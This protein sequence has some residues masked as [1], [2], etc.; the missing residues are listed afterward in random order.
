MKKCVCLLLAAVL[1]LTAGCALAA[2]PEVGPATSETPMPVPDP[3][4][5]TVTDIVDRAEEENL[6]TDTALE[7]FWS[8]GEYDYYFPTVRSRY[9]SVYYSDGTEQTVRAALE[10]GRIAIADLNT[11]GVDYHK[12]AILRV[13]DI[14]DRTETE[15]LLTADA[16]EGF[17]RDEEYTY[18]FASIKSHYIIVHYSDGTQ[19]PIR[20]AMAR[21]DVTIGDL[22]R[23]GIG[24]YKEAIVTAVGMECKM[25]VL[26]AEKLFWS[27]EDYDYYFPN[28]DTEV[29]V[30]LSDGHSWPLH[31]ALMEGLVTVGDLEKYDIEYIRV[32]KE[33]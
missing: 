22:D 24:Y 19:L 18:A 16:L 29:T 1:L 28:Y 33:K 20:E 21:G 7:L 6:P 12:E 17:W 15:A 9:V 2:E 14:V 26:D 31:D 5:V 4:V 30:L 11:F 25:G 10:E 3:D 8:D 27:D 32:E 13:V 23:F